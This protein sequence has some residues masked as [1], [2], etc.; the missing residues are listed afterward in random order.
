MPPIVRR[1]RSLFVLSVNDTLLWGVDN[2][3]PFLRREFS[4]RSAMQLQKNYLKS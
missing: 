2:N 3:F 1:S 4:D